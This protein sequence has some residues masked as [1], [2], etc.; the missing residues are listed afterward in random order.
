[1]LK[2]HSTWNCSNYLNF[3]NF[4]GKGQKMQPKYI[5]QRVQNLRTTA[6][7]KIRLSTQSYDFAMKLKKHPCFYAFMC[8]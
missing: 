2:S 6:L 8:E 1:M 3:G 4:L 7:E 5:V